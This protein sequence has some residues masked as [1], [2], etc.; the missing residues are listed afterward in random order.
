MRHAG[1]GAG[2]ND[3]LEGQAFAAVLIQTVDQLCRDLFFGHA[4]LDDLAHLAE[5]QVSDLLCLAHQLQLPVFLAAA[6]GADLLLIRLEHDIE[7][8]VVG[9]VFVVGQIVFLKAK[10]LDRLGLDG[11]VQELGIRMLAVDHPDR[12]VRQIL[13]RSLD[14]A[15]VG[16]VIGIV[17]ANERNA[18]CDVVARGIVAVDLARQEQC[19]H[20]AGLQQRLHLIKVFHDVSSFFLWL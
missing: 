15:A 7:L 9:G 17:A 11:L 16:E 13:L 20:L 5:G 1:V 3:G 10:R 6:E 8:R 14:V 18:L 4:G 12:E 2:D 19:V